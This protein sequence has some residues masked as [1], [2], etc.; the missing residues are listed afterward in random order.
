MA[1]LTRKRAAAG[2][3]H[4]IAPLPPV[5]PAVPAAPAGGPDWFPAAFCIARDRRA[6]FAPAMVALRAWDWEPVLERLTRPRRRHG[7][8]WTRPVATAIVVEFCR[9]LALKVVA[10][11]Q[12][13]LSPPPLVDRVWQRLLAMPAA[14]TDLCARVNAAAGQPPGNV[15]HVS[16][17][18]TL[19]PEYTKTLQLYHSVF[20]S[21]IHFAAWPPCAASSAAAAMAARRLGLDKPA[22]RP[23]YK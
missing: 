10:G 9:F 14:Y 12:A 18:G 1:P 21:V 3:D 8:G 4:A 22:R 2:D 15:L 6:A 13:G 23:H 11:A 19:G 5:I 7:E 17:G 16:D 20:T